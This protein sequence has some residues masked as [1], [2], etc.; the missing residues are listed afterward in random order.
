[1]N[2]TKKKEVIGVIIL[3]I[4]FVIGAIVYWSNCNTKARI[5]DTKDICI[6]L[7]RSS[8]DQK[9]SNSEVDIA[10]VGSRMTGKQTNADIQRIYTG[11][12][13]QWKKTDT[14][15]LNDAKDYS[16]RLERSYDLQGERYSIE[17]GNEFLAVLIIIMIV[18][19][20]LALALLSNVLRDIISNTVPLDIET[21]YRRNMMRA[22]TGS[23]ESTISA[24]P[25]YS[26]SRTQLAIWITIIGCVYTYAV[27]WDDLPLTEI[28]S[29]ALLLM[30]IAGGTFTAGAILDTTEIEQRI[31]RHQ[32]LYRKGNF[33]KDILSDKNGI[34]IHRFQNVIWTVI[35]IFVYFY[36][37]SN[38]AEGQAP[39]LPKLDQTLL[40]LTGISSATYLILKAREN[41]GQKKPIILNISL[42]LDGLAEKD[43]IM[44]T[45]KGLSDANIDVI[46]S[47][48]D[49][50]H[51]KPDPADPKTK[52]IAAVEPEKSFKIEVKWQGTVGV[53][54]LSLVGSYEDTIKEGESKDIT[55][56][57]K[58]S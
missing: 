22:A 17:S 21:G 4:L 14:L 16:N 56:Q 35:A 38:P 13:S 20:F 12:L 28:N 18:V 43:A 44:S 53:T 31:P 49:I 55:I 5:A 1:M 58:K 54:Q 47:N 51:A 36:K 29:T 46:D 33:F 25:P 10:H 6:H 32:D 11:F 15:S 7:V 8:H 3:S 26:L 30:G 39:G 37:Y 57:L 19:T 24:L 48:G 41:V 34:S 52:F 45:D 23:N 27:F 40:A 42:L 9:F 2:T 50:A